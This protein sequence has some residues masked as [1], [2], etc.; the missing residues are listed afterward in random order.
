MALAIWG[1]DTFTVP[2]PEALRGATQLFGV[3]Y[4]KYRLF[5]LVTGVLLFIGLWPLLQSSWRAPLD[6]C[7]GYPVL[8]VLNAVTQI[9]R[10][11]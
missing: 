2:L 7:G 9:W 11:R 1:G 4:P 10:H 5:V 8:T 6:R 3:Y